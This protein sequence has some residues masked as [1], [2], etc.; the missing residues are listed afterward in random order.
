MGVLVRIVL[1]AESKMLA[2]QAAEDA[3][4]EFQRL[5]D[6]MSDYDQDSELSKLCEN[7]GCQKVSPDLFA[8]L[9]EAKYYSTISSGAFD[10]TVGPMVKLWRR[11]RRQKVLPKQKYIDTAKELVGNHLWTLDEEKQSVTLLKKGMQLDLGAIAKGYAVDRAFEII[12]KHGI[13]TQLVDAGGDFRV[14][15]A[16]PEKTGWRIDVDGENV[17][18]QNIASAT[19]GDRF[20]FV[21]IDAVRYAHI[22]DPKTG[23]GLT[24]HCTAHVSATTAMQADALASAACVLGKEKSRELETALNK[25][26]QNVRIQVKESE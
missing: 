9:K 13:T 15:T 26:G 21:E 16:P 4:A 6:M 5:N 2:D 20:Q 14:G 12:M 10:I 1:Y 11:S 23:L 17:L 19:S 18:T 8:V 24:H 22:I 7:G 3:Y 25:Q